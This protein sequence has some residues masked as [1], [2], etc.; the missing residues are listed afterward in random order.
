MHPHLGHP[1]SYRLDV[2]GIAEGKPIDTD[3]N[4]GP[5]LEV[6]QAPQP[7]REDARLSHDD[8]YVTYKLHSGRGQAMRE[9]L[10]GSRGRWASA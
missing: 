3:E 2:A 6:A 5:R 9:T 8:H 10:T 4:P 7:I 1:F